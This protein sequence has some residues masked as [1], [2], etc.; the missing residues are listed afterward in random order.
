MSNPWWLRSNKKCDYQTLKYFRWFD[1]KHLTWCCLLMF[2]THSLVE[3][4]VHIK[5]TVGKGLF[6]RGYLQS[7][8]P[9]AGLPEA[10]AACVCVLK[11]IET[12]RKDQQRK[13]WTWRPTL[14]FLSPINSESWIWYSLSEECCKCDNALKVYSWPFYL[15]VA[16]GGTGVETAATRARTLEQGHSAATAAALL[17]QYSEFCSVMSYM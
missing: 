13:S 2:S 17:L 9:P 4:C 16:E 8:H 11:E 1:S 12:D 15:D 14:L 5:A 10:E 6:S 3:L 7:A